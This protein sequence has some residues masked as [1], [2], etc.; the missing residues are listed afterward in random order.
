MM[1]VKRDDMSRAWVPQRSLASGWVS[2][3]ATSEKSMRA[4][5]LLRHPIRHAPHTMHHS[6]L[7]SSRFPLLPFPAIHPMP[8]D[9]FQSPAVW[10]SSSL[11][12][13]TS[14]AWLKTQRALS[15]EHTPEQ[16]DAGESDC[17]LQADP[18]APTPQPSG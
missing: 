12:C 11:G 2:D 6:S 9:R 18:S 13:S 17:V 4:G 8:H 1:D 14:S 10:S 7:L 3:W 16:G 15:H 5:K